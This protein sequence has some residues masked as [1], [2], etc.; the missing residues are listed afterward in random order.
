MR[1]LQFI[2]QIC[3]RI[4]HFKVRDYSARRSSCQGSMRLQ[5]K[6]SPLLLAK[7]EKTENLSVENASDIFTLIRYVPSSWNRNRKFSLV[8]FRESTC[9]GLYVEGRSLT[10]ALNTVEIPA[11]FSAGSKRPRDERRKRSERKVGVRRNAGR[12]EK[13][14]HWTTLVRVTQKLFWDR[15]NSNSR[16]EPAVVSLSTRSEIFERRPFERAK[17]ASTFS[18]KP[19]ARRK[20]SL[21]SRA[22]ARNFHGLIPRRS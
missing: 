8:A 17:V 18:R 15:A 12:S 22:I 1:F 3:V 4:W 14:L 9:Q 21:K 10:S 11:R 2:F 16:L 13:E 6:V 5:Y 20:I 7:R 19:R